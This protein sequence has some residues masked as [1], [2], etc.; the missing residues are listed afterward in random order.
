MRAYQGQ[1]SDSRQHTRSTTEKKQQLQEIEDHLAR[2]KS[3]S[4]PDLVASM[5]AKAAALRKEIGD[6]SAKT[7]I[8]I[9]SLQPAPRR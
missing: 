3:H 6:L 5:K 8:G 9:K 7:A 4:A 2:M 1:R